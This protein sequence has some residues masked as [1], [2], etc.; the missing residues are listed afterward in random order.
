MCQKKPDFPKIF[1]GSG[2]VN[3]H[4]HHRHNEPGMD[5]TLKHHLINLSKNPLKQVHF[6]ISV[7]NG[8]AEAQ[9]GNVTCQRSQSKGV[10][11]QGLTPDTLLLL[12]RPPCKSSAL[13]ASVLGRVNED[14]PTPPLDLTPCRLKTGAS[15]RVLS[16]G[17]AS[18]GRWAPPAP[19]PDPTAGL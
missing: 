2:S 1:H 5:E 8:E 16:L 15:A 10:S 11:V 19:H 9:R 4:H 7:F 13:M 17:V 6:G 18:G 14:G 12:A 3:H